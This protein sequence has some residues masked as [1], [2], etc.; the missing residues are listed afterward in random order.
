VRGCAGE[1]AGREVVLCR[2][3]AAGWGVWL[4]V[5]F[6]GI[7]ACT[8]ALDW[9]DFRPDGAPLAMLFPCKPDGHARMLPLAGQT[10]RLTL[11]AC[12]AG[13]VTWALAWTDVQDP[14][15]VAPALRALRE[16]SQAN[17]SAP[18]ASPQ[19]W[20]LPGATPQPDS[21]RWTLRGRGPDGG[22]LSAEVGVFARGTAVFQVTALATGEGASTAQAV[23]TFFSSLRPGG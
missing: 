21:G 19:S 16:A 8:P 4:A 9:R 11:H 23:D 3:I 2:P 13:D 7:S 6:G 12:Q 10:V 1:R 17:L 15:R 14:A 5:V 18:A 22:A 20:N